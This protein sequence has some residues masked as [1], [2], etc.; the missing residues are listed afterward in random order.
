MA[1]T[2]YLWNL[3]KLRLQFLPET[4]YVEGF[5]RALNGGRISKAGE[6]AS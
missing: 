2:V 3:L 4:Q 5:L 6:S 1:N